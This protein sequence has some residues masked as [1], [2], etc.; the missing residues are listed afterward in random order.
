ME[1][2]ITNTK[3]YKLTYGRGYT[4]YLK[5]HIAWATNQGK[6]VL[7]DELKSAINTSLLETAGKLGITLDFIVITPST[8]TLTVSAKPQISPS[9][10]VKLLKGNAARQAFIR[11]PELKSSVY[12]GHLWDPAY[13]IAIHN[14]DVETQMAIFLEGRMGKH[15]SI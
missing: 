6:A 10:I 4:Y 3:D 2:L 5:F 12:G 13:F 14:P 8:I 9:D 11:F 15:A 7:Q 1:K